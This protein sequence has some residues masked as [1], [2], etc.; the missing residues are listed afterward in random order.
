MS[1]PLQQPVVLTRTRPGKASARLARA[2]NRT[3]PAAEHDS[4]TVLTCADP[5]DLA[6]EVA[7]ACKDLAVAGY[8]G[9]DLT[10]RI[11]DLER[12]ARQWA[13]LG[14]GLDRLQQ[15]VHAGF[16]RGSEHA[17]TLPL[18]AEPAIEVLP[19]LL[20]IL[21]TLHVQMTRAYTH[22]LPA[23]TN[24]HHA[25]TRNLAVALLRG[26]FAG[27]LARHCGIPISSRFHVI[28][29]AITASTHPSTTLA[30]AS[31]G[32]HLDTA[33]TH[34]CGPHALSICGTGGGTLLIPHELIEDTDLGEVVRELAD[35]T[36]H[37]L[38]AV[39]LTATAAE[40]PSAAR[41]AHDLL[42]TAT[43]IGVEPGLYRLSD[44]GLHHQL[45]RPSPARDVLHALLSPLED[46][47]ELVHTLATHLANDMNRR[48]TA[49]KLHVHANTVDHRLKRIHQ[50]TGYDPCSPAGLWRLR[51]ALIVRRYTERA[52]AAEKT[53]QRSSGPHYPR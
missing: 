46:H 1:S 14:L 35:T 26:E 17:T 47:P 53:P 52:T 11:T 24:A 20:D 21:E 38:T 7:G 50:I 23:P 25:A 8:R 10:D 9:H 16:R 22:Q 34:R 40:I 42:D 19:R 4:S 39:A 44:L 41:Q 31:P 51:S 45:T 43:T 12:S 18:P 6:A 33:L 30:A 29:V 15:A 28:A 32:T 5:D 2:S 37:A 48:R 36:R 27:P 13:E 3:A 49:R